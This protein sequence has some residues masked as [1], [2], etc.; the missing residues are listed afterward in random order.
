MMSFVLLPRMKGRDQRRVEK[1][2]SSMEEVSQ[3]IL[4][5]TQI[6]VLVRNLCRMLILRRRANQSNRQ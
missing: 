6:E 2:D 1:S 4:P 5:D 3:D